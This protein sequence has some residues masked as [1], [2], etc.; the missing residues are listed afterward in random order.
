MTNALSL[1]LLPRVDPSWVLGVHEEDDHPARLR[2]IVAAP[3]P[4]RPARSDTPRFVCR[5]TKVRAGHGLERVIE[6]MSQAAAGMRTFSI[7]Q[8]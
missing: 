6:S 3:P 2:R 7:N 5:D 8:G 1:T 4:L